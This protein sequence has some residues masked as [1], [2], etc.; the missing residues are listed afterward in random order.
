MPTLEPITYLGVSNHVVSLAEVESENQVLQLIL[1]VFMVD[2][3]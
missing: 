2:A 1:E 3:Q